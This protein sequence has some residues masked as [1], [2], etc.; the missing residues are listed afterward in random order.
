MLPA[1]RVSHVS[2]ATLAHVLPVARCLSTFAVRSL[3]RFAVR[4]SQ[5]RLCFAVRR[6]QTF[7]ASPVLPSL[8]RF[9]VRSTRLQLAGAMCVAAAFNLHAFS[10]PPLPLL[11]VFALPAGES[12]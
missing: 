6:S 10:M 8:A 9:A 3:A 12:C 1:V 11:G 2:F 4:R 7:A 5:H